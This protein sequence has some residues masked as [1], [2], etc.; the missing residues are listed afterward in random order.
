MHL[1]PT[2]APARWLLPICIT[3]AMASG[4]ALVAILLAVRIHPEP[5]WIELRIYRR[6][7]DLDTSYRIRNARFLGGPGFVALSM[8]WVS[9]MGVAMRRGRT[10]AI[11]VA[12]AIAT[13][14][15]NDQILQRLVVRPG[16]GSSATAR[17]DDFIPSGHVA[18]AACAALA[19]VSLMACV[20]APRVALLLA[21]ALAATTTVTVGWASVYQSNHFTLDVIAGAFVAI[22]GMSLTTALAC[23]SEANARSSAAHSTPVGRDVSTQ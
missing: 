2:P 6:I 11:I 21:S 17:L 15:V 13:L 20:D 1:G 19:L 16:P 5:A 4:V 3:L 12:G 22:C 7:V 9:L 8:C 14:I 18:G 23:T 10:A